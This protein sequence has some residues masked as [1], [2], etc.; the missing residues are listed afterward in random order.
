MDPARPTHPL[1]A[2]A[3]DRGLSRAILSGIAA[4]FFVGGVAMTVVVLGFVTPRFNEIFGDFG[5]E[6]SPTVAFVLQTS[7][8]LYRLG[9][10]G[11]LATLAVSTAAAAGLSRLLWGRPFAL[12]ALAI[13]FA[14]LPLVIHAIHLDVLMDMQ[15][16]LQRGGAV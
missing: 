1:L 16:A 15:A 5:V 2:A 14:L 4:C 6:V 10:L 7:D 11:I 12:A 9:P 13:I 8:A 3:D